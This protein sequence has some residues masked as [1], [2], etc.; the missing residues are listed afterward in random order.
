[1]SCTNFAFIS[2][3]ILL[4]SANAGAQIASPHVPEKLKVPAT[5]TVLL[6]AIGKGTQIYVC[7]VTSGDQSQFTWVLDRPEAVLLDNRGAAIGRHYQGPV[8]EAGSDHSKVG[9]QVVERANAPHANAVPWLLLKATSHEGNGT[10]ERVTYIQRVD[11]AGGAA[12]PASECDKSHAGKE[13]AVEYRATYFF[14]IPR[15]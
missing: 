7:R 13:T 4:L 10:F 11:T 14:Y 3:M 6:K 15:P 9:G 5:E 2:L 8:W 12:P 1:M